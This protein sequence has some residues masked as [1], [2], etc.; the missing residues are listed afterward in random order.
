MGKTYKVTETRQ[1]G[2][3]TTTD[4]LSGS[5]ADAAESLARRN[6]NVTDVTIEEE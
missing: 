3:Q 4:G 2:S 1:D 5:G 6:P